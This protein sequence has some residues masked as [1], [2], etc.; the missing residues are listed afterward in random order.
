MTKA[1]AFTAVEAISFV[2][3]EHHR[4]AT[5]RDQT[6]QLGVLLVDIVLRIDD[7]DDHVRALDRSQRLDDREL[8]D[9]FP[10]ARL[11][12]DAGGVDQRVRDRKSKRLNSSP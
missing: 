9:G 4:A 6:H 10:D 1:L 7:R 11:A 2:D 3:G 12:T 5:L 8:V